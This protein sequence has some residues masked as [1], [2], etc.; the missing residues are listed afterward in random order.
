MFS[1]S[2]FF[3]FYSNNCLVIEAKKIVGNLTDAFSHRSRF[4][5]FAIFF[6]LVDKSKRQMNNIN[7]KMLT[8]WGWEFIYFSRKFLW[9]INDNVLFSSYAWKKNYWQ[10]ILQR[11]W[12]KK[13]CC[14]SF[15]LGKVTS[16][17]ITSSTTKKLNHV[18]I[19]PSPHQKLKIWII[20][21]YP[22]K[23][24]LHRNPDLITSSKL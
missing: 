8:K 16:S 6:K 20:R 7:Q 23:W 9:T 22:L 21:K 24:S 17:N 13:H 4:S 19:R 14:Q 5:F 10:K 15:L 1:V 18:T 2:I 11:R 12:N 3:T